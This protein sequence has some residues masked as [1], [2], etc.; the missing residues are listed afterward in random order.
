[1][2][3]APFHHHHF[4]HVPHL[5]LVVVRRFAI[6]VLLAVAIVLLL[7]GDSAESAVSAAAAFCVTGWAFAQ[8]R[9]DQR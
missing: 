5:R 4:A 9:R 8:R 1:M 7:A 3:T 6:S 2:T